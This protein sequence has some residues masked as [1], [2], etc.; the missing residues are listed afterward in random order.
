MQV[1]RVFIGL[2][3]NLENPTQQIKQAIIEISALP[4]IELKQASNLYQS[5]AI[6]PKQPDYINAVIALE[7]T[8][9]PIELLDALQRI[10][11]KH[12]RK[13]EIKWGPR[14]LDCDI[15]LYG[16]KHIQSQRL[17]VP[18]PEMKNR[19]FV[20]IPLSEI[21]KDLVFPDNS[22]IKQY[23]KKFDRSQIQIQKQQPVGVFKDMAVVDSLTQSAQRSVF[24][25]Q[26]ER[27]Q[28]WRKLAQLK[29]NSKNQEIL[30][31]FESNPKRAEDFSLQ[32]GDLYLDYSKNFIDE[33]IRNALVDLAKSYDVPGAISQLL[34]GYPVNTT[35]QRSALHSALRVDAKAKASIQVG[36]KDI[37]PEVLEERQKLKTFVDKLHAREWVGATDK[38]ITDIVNF[39]IGGSDLGPKM[40]V[41][42]LQPYC[43][44]NIN[45]HFVANIDPVNFDNV[46]EKLNPETTLFALSSKSFSTQET[47]S[48]ATLAQKW[49]ER[50]LHSKT[51]PQHFIA[52]TAN[53]ARAIAWGIAKEKILSFWPWVGGR[54]SIWSSIGFSVAVALGGDNFDSFLQGANEMDRHFAEAPLEQ[55]M[56][57]IMALIGIWYRNICNAPTHAICPYSYLLRSF[58]AYIQQLDMESN[59]K[60]AQPNGDATQVQTAPI[61]WGGEGTNAQ[62]AFFQL[63]HQGHHLVPLDF[64]LAKK[65]SSAHKSAHQQ[66]M[67]NCL[68]QAKA[69]MEGDQCRDKNQPGFEKMP[70]NKPSNILLLDEISP[71]AL[72]QLIALY[73]HKVFVQGVIWQ[74]NSFD[75]PGVELG[76]KL[77][78][79]LTDIL[80]NKKNVQ[81]LDGSTEK[82]LKN[83]L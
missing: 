34:S 21:D 74:I 31:Y 72:G 45:I 29:E 7:T 76:K 69:L 36:D 61:I 19:D 1:N 6:G 68:A 44:K 57:V 80:Q 35:E 30:D 26:D 43:S 78:S 65:S 2:G 28:V 51:F 10:E 22:P 70:G 63:L 42:S 73:E 39:G 37:V 17:T 81:S 64:I 4:N 59:G 32:V 54:F 46:V 27:N 53:P 18:H 66:L 25:K 47:L 23:L 79:T 11:Q 38:P 75:Q 13:R 24:A 71:K 8:L 15:L 67:V 41:E 55:N 9:S 33:D 58:P 20:M 49:L 3:S 48:N 50:H 52:I 60:S 83:I 77:A 62:H 12:Y 5:C 40:V 14:T 82:L 16:Q 56:P